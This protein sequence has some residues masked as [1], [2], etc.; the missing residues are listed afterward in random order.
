MTSPLILDYLDALTFLRPR[1]QSIT[2]LLPIEPGIV[3]LEAG[4]PSDPFVA[5]ISKRRKRGGSAYFVSVNVDPALPRIERVEM[6]I[7]IAT[8]IWY[9]EET[10]SNVRV[11]ASAFTDM[12]KSV[13][14]SP[15]RVND[16]RERWRRLGINHH[17]N[18]IP[19]TVLEDRP[20][21]KVCPGFV[22]TGAGAHVAQPITSVN[23]TCYH[24]DIHDSCLRFVHEVLL[25][26]LE[27]QRAAAKEA[28]HAGN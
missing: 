3:E 16:P 27:M 19:V 24:P 5:L 25:P 9:M 15:S 1:V 2:A 21:C 7:W 8:N 6:N 18:Q 4:D 11:T 12:C 28:A 22:A 10:G 17:Y 23:P 26:A 14:C 13:G 20:R